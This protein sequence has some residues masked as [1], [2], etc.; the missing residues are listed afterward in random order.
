MARQRDYAAEY[1]RRIERGLAA[2]KTRQEARGHRIAGPL[3]EYG[4]KLGPLPRLPRNATPEQ[5]AERA[6]I[7]ARRRAIRHAAAVKR[8][9][10]TGEHAAYGYREDYPGSPGGWHWRLFASPTRLVREIRRLPGETETAVN[11]WGDLV[12]GYADRRGGRNQWRR[13][14]TGNAEGPVAGEGGK[15]TELEWTVHSIRRLTFGSAGQP[16]P[17]EWV[18][19]Y[20]LIVR[21]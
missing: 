3:A 20:E 12:V 5:R 4:G 10:A 14:G 17:F 6:A 21:L 16:G 2:G 15:R 19:L 18:R 8:A 13:I 9:V 7:V 1:R 11:A